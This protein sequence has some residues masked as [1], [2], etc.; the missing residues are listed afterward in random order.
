MA[1]QLN[2]RSDEACEIASSL[3]ERL[4]TTTTSV[5]VD[6][7]RAYEARLAPPAKL[8]RDAKRRFETLMALARRTSKHK[9]PGASSDHSDF[10]GEDGLPR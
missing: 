9:R 8:G 3:A 7:L 1:R 6:A 10:Y 5:V 4:G 2:I